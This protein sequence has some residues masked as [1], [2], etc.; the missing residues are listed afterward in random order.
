[1]PYSKQ[2]TPYQLYTFSQLR[3]HQKEWR[4]DAMDYVDIGC[5]LNSGGLLPSL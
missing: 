5:C 4:Q 2:L 3:Q 1:M